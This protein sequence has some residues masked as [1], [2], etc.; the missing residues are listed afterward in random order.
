MIPVHRFMQI[1]YIMLNSG[2]GGYLI[3]KGNIF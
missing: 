2:A 1:A 3:I